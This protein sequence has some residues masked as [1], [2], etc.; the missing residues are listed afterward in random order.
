MT[1][2]KI[3]AAL[4]ARFL[5]AHIFKFANSQPLELSAAGARVANNTDLK[6]GCRTDSRNLDDRAHLDEFDD[7]P[8]F[9]HCA[10]PVRKPSS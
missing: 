3:G 8:S 5:G 2:I 4:P 6:T 1:P 10:G 7:D 9:S